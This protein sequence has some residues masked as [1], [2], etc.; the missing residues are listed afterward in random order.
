MT[1][2]TA[3][4]LKKSDGGMPPGFRTLA[5]MR[6]RRM[7][8]EYGAVDIEASGIFIGSSAEQEV[9]EIALSQTCCAMS[10]SFEDGTK[11]TAGFKVVKLSCE[12]NFNGDPSYGLHIVS[13][14]AVERV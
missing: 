10:L 1:K 4:L 6:V 9:R 2:G 14:G 13:Q 7:N 11:I 3:F 12:G 8:I 5:G